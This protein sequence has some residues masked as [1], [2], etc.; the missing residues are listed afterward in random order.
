MKLH[1]QGFL[2]DV[3]KKKTT[4]FPPPQL[5]SLIEPGQVSILRK[6]S[7]FFFLILNYFS[8]ALSLVHA[9]Q[10]SV[11]ICLHFKLIRLKYSPG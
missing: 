8:E 10:H 4:L 11:L 3:K 5:T 6:M 2:R 9:A 7:K 1:I